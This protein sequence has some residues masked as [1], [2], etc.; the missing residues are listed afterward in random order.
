M[1]GIAGGLGFLEKS[2]LEKMALK[3]SHRGPD[4]L[5]FESFNDVHLAHVRLSIIDLSELS[6]QPIWD[7]TSR[8]CITFNGEIYN[9]QALRDELISL[10]FKFKSKGD[11]EV[12]L[13]LY[14]HYGEGL[15]EKLNG[16]F[17]FAIWDAEK[18]ELLV[19]R[20][21]FGVK[22]LYYTENEQG[23]YFAS[24]M[25]S[26]L[27]INSVKR[28]FNYDALYRT[29]IF[30]YSPGSG[31]L[32]K[33]IKKIEPGHFVRVKDKKVIEC[34]E[35]WRWPDYQ[36]QGTNAEELADGVLDTLQ[37]SVKDQLVADVPVGAFLSGGLDS[38]L[39]VA[40]ANENKDLNIK[41]FTIDTT[42]G[43]SKNDGFEDDLP[44]A[45]KVAEFLDVDLDILNATPDIVKQL[46]EMIYHL[47]E[48][49]A[50]PA[51]LNVMMI[52]RQAKE[53]GIKVLLSGAGGDDVFS[54]YRR[55]FAIKFE[56]YW[57][58]LPCP[59][60]SWL[61][62]ITSALPKE[63]PAFRRLSKAFFY[64]DMTANERLLSYF[65]WIDPAVV[66][67]LFNDE[68]KQQISEK[69]M[70][71][72]YEQLD[73]LPYD[74]PLEKMLFLERSY[75]LVDHNFNYTDKMSMAYGVEVRVPFLDRR[76]VN[77]AAGIPSKFKQNGRVGK[78]ILKKAAESKLPKSIIYR[79]K[80]GFGAPL[81]EWLKGDLVPL[82]DDYLSEGKISARGVFNPDKVRELIDL[83]RNG[84]EDY[85]YPIFALLCFEVWCEQFIGK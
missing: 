81:R 53:K 2:V 52:C 28:D 39:L 59:A 10:G 75:F 63:K 46:P 54:G 32:L 7:C 24:E 19:A 85:S 41:C 55:H 40:L 38:S 12:L 25:K 5:S 50:D 36:P 26:L 15:F 66:R 9:Y 44:Y 27:E 60:R 42:D 29:L 31:T 16:I 23:F 64:A 57:G 11:A 1:C 3:M 49:Q 37:N 84:K 30:L 79:P 69:P 67:E 48:L 78:W 77:Y 82:V 33:D 73:S 62:K 74:D 47:D 18:E 43:A 72:I 4:N 51:P 83:D 13:N 68:V 45:K 56:R 58:W 76:V 20:D 35:F 34:C 65:Y 8:A 22:P 80:S 14:L 71:F 61:K 6:N 21:H 70:K 17:S